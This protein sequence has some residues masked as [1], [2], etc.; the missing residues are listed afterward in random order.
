[1][2]EGMDV[3]KSLTLRDPAQGFNLPAGDAILN[4]TIEQR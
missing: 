3:V 2:I 1:V 4:I